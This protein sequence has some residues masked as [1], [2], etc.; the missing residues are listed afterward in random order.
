MR[1]GRMKLPPESGAKPTRTNDWMIGFEH[2]RNGDRDFN[3]L[4]IRVESL[5]AVPEPGSMVML[6]TGLIG[7]A[8]AAR[9]R[10]KK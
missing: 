4:V 3:D 1:R 10:L 2:T 8:G 9:R 7:L 5:D 6:G